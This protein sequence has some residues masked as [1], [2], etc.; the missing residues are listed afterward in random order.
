MTKLDF[1]YKPTHHPLKIQR[2]L[3]LKVKGRKYQEKKLYTQAFTWLPKSNDRMKML[4]EIM[5]SKGLI[6]ARKNI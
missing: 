5:T 6:D 3:G 1:K 2:T 4:F